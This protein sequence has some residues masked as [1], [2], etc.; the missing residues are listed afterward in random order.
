MKGHTNRESQDGG[1]FGVATYDSH[2][3]MKGKDSSAG[4]ER[5]VTFTDKDK[6]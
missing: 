2:A 4:K 6:T 3:D 1:M 5:A